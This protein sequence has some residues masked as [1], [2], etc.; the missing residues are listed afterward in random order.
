MQTEI[1]KP[2]YISNEEYYTDEGKRINP[3]FEHKV[4]IIFLVQGRENNSKS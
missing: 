3:N 2:N 1:N 4:L